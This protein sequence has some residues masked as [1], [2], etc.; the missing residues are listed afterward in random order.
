MWENMTVYMCGSELEGILCG[1]YDA[2][3]SGLG[4]EHVRL[5]IRGDYQE[6]ELFT[7]YLDVEEEDPKER[8]QKASKVL[9]AISGKLSQEIYRQV[10][11]ASLS[12]DPKRADKIYR[13]LIQAFRLGPSAADRLQLPEVCDI[14]R[15]CRSVHNEAHQLIEF[16]R[17]SQNREGVLISRIGPEND[18]LTLVSPHFA[19]RLPS[20]NW[21]IYDEKRRKAAVHPRG[22]RWFLVHEA[23]KEAEEEAWG[24]WLKEKT[25]EGVYQELWKSFY[26]TIA[27]RER[28][29]PRCQR[30]HLPLRFRPYMTEFD[31]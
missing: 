23:V 24:Y 29:N 27:I 30:T 7:Q 31:S 25:D 21:V 9:S 11:T 13:Y 17:F 26:E 28:E 8:A 4:H 20:E 6:P 22:G 15:L 18:V 2:W 16:I 19:D 10:C 14:F 12:C 3:T 5:E 1:I